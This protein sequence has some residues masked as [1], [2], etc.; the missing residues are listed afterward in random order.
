MK[1]QGKN[2]CR[3]QEK[4]VDVNQTNPG[5]A[6]AGPAA[7]TGYPSASTTSATGAT[8]PITS[9]CAL[10]QPARNKKALNT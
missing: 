7:S 3:Q 4:V 10:S 9:S 2:N 1:Q 5:P 8:N 6:S